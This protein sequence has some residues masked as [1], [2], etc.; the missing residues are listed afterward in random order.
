MAD[1]F[2]VRRYAAEVALWEQSTTIQPE[3]RAA[4]CIGQL[5]GFAKTEGERL[6]SDPISAQQ[7]RHGAINRADG[8]PFQGAPSSAGI[9]YKDTVR[10]NS[11]RSSAW[12]QN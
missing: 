5:R 8:T 4:L 9:S 1:S 11:T 6:L 7:L 10:S 3:R 12:H 2:P